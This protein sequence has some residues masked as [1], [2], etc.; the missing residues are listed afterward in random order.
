[1][2]KRLILL[3]FSVCAI[4]GLL[5]ASNNRMN[6][7]K[8]VMENVIFREEVGGRSVDF[9]IWEADDDRIYYLILPSFFEK[10]T[11][12]FLVEYDDLFYKIY[13]DDRLYHNRDRWI[14]NLKEEMHVV[15][16]EDIW[17]NVYLDKQLQVL[18]SGELPTMMVQVEAQEALY[19]AMDYAHKN[20]VEKGEMIFFDNSGDILLDTNLEVFRVRGNVTAM[21]AKKSFA[22]T[23]PNAV[24]LCNMEASQ[25]WN[26]LANAA[27]GSQ[28]RNKMM[29]DWAG[30]VSEGYHPESEFVELFVNGEYQGLYLLT[31]TVEIGEKKV[32][33]A[34][35][36]FLLEM[37]LDYY[38]KENEP[39][40]KTDSGHTFVINA[41]SIVTEPQIQGVAAVLNEVESALYATDGKG[42]LTEKKLSELISIDSWTDAW[43][44][45]EIS[46]DHDMGVVSQFA[47][48][49]AYGEGKLEAGPVW[50]FD[51]TFGNGNVPLFRNPRCLIAAMPDIKGIRSTNHNRWFAPMYQNDEFRTAL[52]AKFETEFYDK[53][54][55]LTEYEID[56]YEVPIRRSALLDSLKWNSDGN[57]DYFCPPEGFAIP[58]EGD[59]HKYD[60]LD[61]HTDMIKDFLKEKQQFLKELWIDGAKFEVIV[62]EH[63]EDGMN[64]ELNN[65]IYEWI[66]K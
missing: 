34:K 58:T 38:V 56:A 59:Y 7:E 11:A 53:I 66:K 62:E 24:S 57:W 50:D 49:D 29:L 39:S 2:K 27:D 20:S 44:L 43:L 36:D 10:N 35:N 60:V 51:G 65:N 8:E 19:E 3:G 23:L 22:F 18:K 61:I 28:I 40:I 37:T 21:F 12:D 47:Y 54:S 55:R 16:V 6:H 13:I 4:V 15:R 1:M 45:R 42:R 25:N 64:L 63:Y 5:L 9:K 48:I 26:L 30:E 14:E 52:I 31:E 33:C 46:S 41:N 32:S 17:G